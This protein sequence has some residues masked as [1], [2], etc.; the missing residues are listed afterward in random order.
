MVEEVQ[1][2]HGDNLL[3]GSLYGPKLP[4]RRP[5][6]ALVFGSGAQDRR[7][8]GVGASLGRHFARNGL[9]CLAW[10]RPGVG[11]STGDF[12]TQTFQDRA[13]EALAAVQFL[14]ERPEVRADAVGLWGHS[15]GGMVV[16]LAASRSKKVSFVIQVSG[17]QG[18][19]WRQDAVR[20]E[21]ELRAG[22][23]PEQEIKEAVAFA[24]LRLALIRGAGPFEELEA[25]QAK[26]QSRPWFGSVRWCD[27]TLF[28]AARRN[29][30]H[31]TGPSWERVHCPVLVIYGDQDTSS[32]PPEPL[33]AVIRAGLAKG[34]NTDVTVRIFAG[35]D[36]ALCT[37]K[38]GGSNEQTQR[39]K[40]R[41]GEGDPPFVP[42]YLDAM[43]NWLGKRFSTGP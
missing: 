25:A 9:V 2:R 41:E 37:T 16:P 22:G 3:A 12:N 1:F 13:G 23:F 42:G 43:T 26:A 19:A 29:V 24:R 28:Y 8:G 30:G 40:D 36:H 6:V 33:V 18:A 7:C 31:D 14:R 21:A 4:S 11:R 20:V 35:A 38:T 10:D 39:A 17:W 34:R 32:G 15:Q 27:R 5:A